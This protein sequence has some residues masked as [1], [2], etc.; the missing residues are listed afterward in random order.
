MILHNRSYVVQWRHCSKLECRPHSKD[1]LDHLFIGL[2]ANKY[3]KTV[4]PPLF[5]DIFRGLK[6]L[7]VSVLVGGFDHSVVVKY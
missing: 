3:K 5:Y 4:D 2:V 7:C 6:A 1:A